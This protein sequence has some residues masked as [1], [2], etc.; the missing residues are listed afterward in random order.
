MTM[1]KKNIINSA[2]L[3]I[4]LMLAVFAI[5]LFLIAIQFLSGGKDAVYLYIESLNLREVLAP[6]IA[7][8]FVV[9]LLPSSIMFLISK[10][11]K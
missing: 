2:K 10:F 8:F 6:I 5:F 3:S 11:N 7:V 1:F 4:R 9:A